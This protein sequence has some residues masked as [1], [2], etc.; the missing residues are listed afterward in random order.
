MFPGTLKQPTFHDP[1]NRLVARSEMERRREYFDQL[2]AKL[3]GGKQHPLVLLIKQCLNNSP[4]ERPTAGEVLTAVE[5]MKIKIEG[6][7][8]SHELMKTHVTKQV[9]IARN[10]QQRDIEMKEK[11]EEIERLHQ[12]L[13][14]TEV[15]IHNNVSDT[16]PLILCY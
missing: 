3:P 14:Q 11:D 8:D 4:S 6:P 13:D 10:L 5:D 1:S 15:Y 2:E 12:E 7:Y 16:L 9:A